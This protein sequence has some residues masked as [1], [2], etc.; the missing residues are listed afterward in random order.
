VVAKDES[1]IA[2]TG[3]TL[4]LIYLKSKKTDLRTRGSTQD[5]FRGNAPV[6]RL[7]TE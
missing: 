2:F 7:F 5:S 1:A 4:L 3:T 6:E